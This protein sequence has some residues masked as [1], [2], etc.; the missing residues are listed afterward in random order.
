MPAVAAGGI[1]TAATRG[2]HG[3]TMVRT[4]QGQLIGSV[5]ARPAELQMRFREL[6]QRAAEERKPLLEQPSQLGPFLTISREV[7]SGGAEVARL[8]GLRLGWAVL[9][10]Q[11]VEDLARR[12]ELS[13][14]M[15]ELMDETHS[16]WFHETMLNL[17]NS[18]IVH[19][20]SYLSILGKV[21]HLA[22]YEGKVIFV[23]RGGHLLLPRDAGLRVRV[24]APRA[25]RLATFQARE[26]LNADEAEG[27]FDQLEAGRANFVRRHFRQEPDDPSQYDMVIDSVVFGIDGC[28]ELVCRALELR[29][30]ISN[31]EGDR[32]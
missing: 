4:P 21:M 15:L 17:M 31:E 12:L 23:G 25:A 29:G 11:L 9:D 5:T 10:K 13:P 1:L 16:N 2:I 7:G 22:A 14:Q 24:I 27:E 3:G 32:G 30:L 28:V 6:L 19:Q 18:R 26:G 8:V 20:N